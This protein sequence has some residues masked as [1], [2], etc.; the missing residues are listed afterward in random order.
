VKILVCGGRKYQDEL[1]ITRAL[2]ECGA[3]NTAVVYGDARNVLLHGAAPGADSIA[4][5]V[6]ARLGWEVRKYRAKWDVDGLAAGPLRN[7]QM[8]D[9]NDDIDLVL[10]FP[11]GKGTAD[12]VRRAKRRGLD[13]RE[14]AAAHQPPPAAGQP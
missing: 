13:V 7:Q 3:F 12:M 8:L 11:G 5:R 2:R 4:A 14:P 1:A 10:V 6:A 9:E